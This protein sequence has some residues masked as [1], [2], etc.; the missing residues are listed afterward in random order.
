MQEQL[1]IDFPEPEGFGKPE[2]AEPLFW[3]KE[4]RFL[5]RW[6]T[7]RGGEIRRIQFR[8]GLRW[9]SVALLQSTPRESNFFSSLRIFLRS[10]VVES[11][12]S[13]V[14]RKMYISNPIL[15]VLSV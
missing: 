1:K 13:C 8:K 9:A 12:R 2:E 5:S 11:I 10:S 4:V 15:S 6:T 14:E 7:E 3:V